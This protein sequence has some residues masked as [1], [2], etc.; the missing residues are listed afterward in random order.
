MRPFRFG[1]PV[2]LMATCAGSTLSAQAGQTLA[3]KF[4]ALESIRAISLSPS[5]TKIAYVAPASDGSRLV[6][7]D[8]AG[9]GVPKPILAQRRDGETLRGC[10]WAT[11]N[12][13][14][15]TNTSTVN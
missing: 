1:L 11:D 6:V 12:R 4:G 9:G 7:A 13:L 2:L 14:V 15:C 5:G 3:D 10:R 8:L